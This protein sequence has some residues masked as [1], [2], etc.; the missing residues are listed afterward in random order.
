MRGGH[1]AILEML[2]LHDRSMERLGTGADGKVNASAAGG[3]AGG[4]AGA[5][6]GGAQTRPGAGSAQATPPPRRPQAGS[7]GAPDEL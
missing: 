2:N 3:F 7:P 4:S 5:S 6:A 1:D